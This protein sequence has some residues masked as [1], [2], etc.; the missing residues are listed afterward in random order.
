MRVVVAS[1]SNVTTLATPIISTSIYIMVGLVC[2]MRE[3]GCEL[4][5]REN[6]IEILGKWIWKVEKTESYMSAK[7]TIDGLCHLNIFR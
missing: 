7:R 5:L 1:M 6:V 2:S 4:F 3:I